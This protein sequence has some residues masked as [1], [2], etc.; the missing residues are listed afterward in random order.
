MTALDAS[1]RA[2]RGAGQATSGHIWRRGAPFASSPAGRMLTIMLTRDIVGE[3]VT[4]QAAEPDAPATAQSIALADAHRDQLGLMPAGA[5]LEHARLGFLLVAIDASGEVLGYV[6]FRIAR[7]R[8][9]VAHLCV[10]PADRK[11]GIARRLI[12][13]LRSRH[14]GIPYIQARCRQD[15]EAHAAWQRLGFFAEGESRGRG[16]DGAMLTRFVMRIVADDL[17]ATS[18]ADTGRSCVV[19]DACVLYGLQD[20]SRGE[21]YEIDALRMGWLEDLVE[22]AVVDEIYND[23]LAAKDPDLKTR[24]RAFAATFRQVGSAGQ[25]VDEALKR[26]R[27][28]LPS[29][30]DLRHVARC[31]ANDAV[32]AFI[33]L[34]EDV[35]AKCTE[36]LEA[37]DGLR[38]MRPSELV[39]AIDSLARATEY[40]PARLAGTLLEDRRVSSG[41]DGLAIRFLAT[42]SQEA[43]TELAARLR[44]LASHVREVEVRTINMNARPIGLYAIDRRL[45]GVVEIPVARVFS[46]ANRTP[47]EARALARFVAQLVQHDA[48]ESRATVTAVTESSL[49]PALRQGLQQEGFIEVDGL[50]IHL[51]AHGV[52]TRQSLDQELVSIVKSVSGNPLPSG[53]KAPIVHPAHFTAGTT[54][55]ITLEDVL[56]PV[57]VADASYPTYIIPIQP[58]WAEHLFD[59]D[60]AEQGLLGAD[61]RLRLSCEHVYYRSSRGPKICAPGRIL[62]Y[63]SG[64]GGHE[65]R[66]GIRACS[67]L[68]DVQVGDPDDLYHRFRRFGVYARADVRRAVGK[69][70]CGLVMAMQFDRTEVFPSPVPL[71][72]IREA[73]RSRTTIPGPICLTGP[74]FLRLYSSGARRRT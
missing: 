16:R 71:Q 2:R 41:F 45:P 27:G 5:F 64:H 29:G 8:I 30:A 68:R 70:P 37:T 31:A 18:A 72:E 23:I 39:L 49:S 22:F 67:R 1:E 63:V 32:D 73:L 57:K 21:N 9:V 14:P 6:L 74:T 4:I 60:L 65:L 33:T 46:P 48:T 35:L 54:N 13:E 61:I 28:I 36:I 62:W 40:A 7:N 3:A 43:S 66:A 56:H 34:D 26:L 24:R 19:L 50:L 55:D 17:F 47:A 58:R 44:A 53:I 10:R 12:E 52:Q 11:R 69:S 42:N 38:V 51:H 59:T 20:S 15:Y 25:A